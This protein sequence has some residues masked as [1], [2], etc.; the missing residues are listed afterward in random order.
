[1]V[2]GLSGDTSGVLFTNVLLWPVTISLNFPKSVVTKYDIGA[3]FPH[4]APKDSSVKLY[5]QEDVEIGMYVR[6]AE[7]FSLGQI[8]EFSVTPAASVS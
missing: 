2:F 5:Y 8:R 7:S 3:G 4:P 6:T 1:V